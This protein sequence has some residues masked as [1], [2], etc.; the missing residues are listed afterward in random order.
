MVIVSVSS[1]TSCESA[2]EPRRFSRTGTTRSLFTV[3]FDLFFVV[4]AGE[5]DANGDE[6]VGFLVLGDVG[7]DG[8]SSRRI[9][10][11]ILH[12]AELEGRDSVQL[13]QEMG[14]LANNLE[15]EL[16]YDLEL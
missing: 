10:R 16:P 4:F 12:T 15:M 11:A 5:L 9:C 7:P 6:I 1:A 14:A 3:L 8:L 13:W 2:A